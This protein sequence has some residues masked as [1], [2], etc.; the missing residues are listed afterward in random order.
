MKTRNLRRTF[1]AAIL[2]LVALSLTAS[3][4][5]QG[6]SGG[7]RGS[8]G[9]AG[10]GGGPPAGVGVDRGL[11]NASDRSNGRSDRGLETASGRSNGRSDAGL[12]RARLAA[13]NRR[14]ADRELREHPGIATTLHLN[15][16][17]L[18][19]GYQ[20]ALVTNPNL[21][22]GQY[23]AATRLAQNLSGR[24]PNITRSAILASLA[25]GNS[26]GRTLQNLGL[27]SHEANNAKKQA[28]RELKQARH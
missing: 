1:F 19:S 22:F 15:A 13:D 8:G 10:R 21:K 12:N 17:N 18:R 6:K 26:L 20:A 25:D 27:S 2:C 9:G 14:E 7:G 24:F 23:V 11:G 3:A 5:G 28:E 16:N 4:F